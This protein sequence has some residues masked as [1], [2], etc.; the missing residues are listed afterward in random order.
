MTEANG[1]KHAGADV[2]VVVSSISGISRLDSEERAA[3]E[4]VVGTACPIA[5]PKL[6]F[7]E[8][9]GACGALGM[10]AALAWLADAPVTCLVSG[11]IPSRV[12]HALVTT[13]GYYGNASAVVMSTAEVSS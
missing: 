10:S 1:S 2:D 9:L 6:L 3:I 12:D 13:M 5:A 4:Q 11:T 8:T 7:G